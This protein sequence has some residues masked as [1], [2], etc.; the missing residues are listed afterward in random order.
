MLSDPQPRVAHFTTAPESLELLLRPEI[1]DLQ[2]RGV[3]VHAIS[4]PF[5]EADLRLSY[6]GVTHHVI[7]SLTRRI[8]PQSDA[9]AIQELWRVLGGLDL[10]VLHTHTPKAAIYGRALGRLKRIPVVVNTIRGIPVREPPRRLSE[11]GYLVLE[12]LAGC[13]SDAEFY[14]NEGD[15]QLVGRLHQNRNHMVGG[16][17]DLQRYHFDTKKREERRTELGISDDTILI[18]GVGRRVADKGIVEFSKAAER[19]VGKASF[20]WIG[21][22]DPEKKDAITGHFSN[23]TFLGFSESMEEWYSAF[24]IFVLPSYR[25]GFPRSAME[26]AAVGIPIV[27]TEIRGTSGLGVEGE[28]VRRIPPG[29]VDALVVVLEELIEHPEIRIELGHA[30]HRQALKSYDFHRIA[31]LYVETYVEIARKKGISLKFNPP[32]P[33]L[34]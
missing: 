5:R 15:M 28:E 7:P 24:D 2:A 4:G 33:A 13:F 3:E 30:A 25:E 29:D 1:L 20:L 8:S 27:T 22:E 17:I 32:K 14:L 11:N 18:G 34:D 6:E 31:S 21:P 9:K 10:D 19:L 16:G 26:A 12:Q 23:L